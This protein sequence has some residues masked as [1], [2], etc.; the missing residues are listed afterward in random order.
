[1]TKKLDDEIDRMFMLR[2]Q[3]RG[4]ENQIKEVNTEFNKV[5]EWCL[6]RMDEVGTSTARGR[7]ASVSITESVV[8]RIEDWGAVQD[9]IMEND[10][11]YLVHKRI[12]SGPWKELLDTGEIVPGIS[13]YTK[14]QISLR[15]LGD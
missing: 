2:E 9:W 4:L 5:H 3:K 1:M 10:G 8:P 14:R 7:Y 12:S 6:E 15:K 11:I 13:P